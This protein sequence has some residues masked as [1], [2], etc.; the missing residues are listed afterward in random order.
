MSVQEFE[1]EFEYAEKLT[2]F[3]SKVNR[4]CIFA[5]QEYQHRARSIYYCLCSDSRG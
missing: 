5:S 3:A 1:A 2:E 4:N